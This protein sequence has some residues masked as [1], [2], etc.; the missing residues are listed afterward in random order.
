[1]KRYNNLFQNLISLENLYL[2]EKR[3]RKGKQNK[4]EVQEYLINLDQNI[5][6]LHY[7]LRFKTYKVSKYYHF[8]VYEPKQRKISKLPYKDRIVHH[9]LINI[10][11]D[12]LIKSFI[13]QTYSCIKGRGIHRGL[14]ELTKY[15]KNKENTKYCLKLDIKKYYPSISND[16]LKQLFR[17]KFKD[18]DLLWLID[19]IIESHK[20]C[21]LGNYTSQYFANFYLNCFCHWLKENK[22]LKYFLIYCDDIVILG[23]NKEYLH[24]LRKEIQIYLK[25]NLNLELSKYQVFSVESRGIDFL[26]YKSYHSYIRLRKKI[27]KNWIKMLNKYSNQ[28]SKASYYGWLIH[29]NTINLQNK[30][31]K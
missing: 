18:K 19:L 17:R 10:I 26:G 12:I 29:A 30:Y 24:S 14:R 20:G 22:R 16:K 15:L 6:E 1:M 5:L 31:L 7:E 3:A 27:K 23:N 13:S 8:I 4:K 25:E 9:A 21:P 2:A 11:G 28:K